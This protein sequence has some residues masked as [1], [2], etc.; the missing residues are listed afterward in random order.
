M[1]AHS[2]KL[3]RHQKRKFLRKN[4]NIPTQIT[5]LEIYTVNG[6]RKIRPTNYKMQGLILDISIGGALIKIFNL[7]N[8]PEIKIGNYFLLEFVINSEKIRIVSN[9]INITEDENVH[10]KFIKILDQKAY[11]INDFIFT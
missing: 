4:C 1:L 2:N 6:K 5:I 8:Y 9:I 3:R 7:H 10:T 11:I